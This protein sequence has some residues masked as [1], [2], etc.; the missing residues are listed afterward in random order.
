[1]KTRI[2]T[3]TALLALAMTLTACS[4]SSTSKP[5]PAACKD[6]WTEKMRRELAEGASAPGKAPAECDGF[7]DKTMQSFATEILTKRLPRPRMPE[8]TPECRAWIKKDNDPHRMPG[9][10]GTGPCGYMSADE[11]G[12]AIFRVSKDMTSQDATSSP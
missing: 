7:D 9:A 8:I 5:D 12:L 2:V 3:C 4:G 6:A 1:M 11:L 10:P